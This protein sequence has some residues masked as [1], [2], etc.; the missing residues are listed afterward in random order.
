MNEILQSGCGLRWK[1]NRI[2]T[3]IRNGC[4]ELASTG[5]SRS[6]QKKRNNQIELQVRGKK[7]ISR[8]HIH[9]GS[10]QN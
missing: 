2:R 1:I 10:K 9:D 3:S 7:T 6:L 8:V 4:F 5:R